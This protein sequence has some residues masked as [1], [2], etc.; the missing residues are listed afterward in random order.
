MAE[1]P[2]ER[3]K[4]ARHWLHSLTRVHD[5]LAIAELDVPWWTY[6]A[7]D[8]VDVWLAARP[9]PARVFEYGSG[10]S[11][12]WLARRAAE[13][14]SVEHHPGFGAM[15]SERLSGEGN[16]HLEV[17]EATL[18]TQP[19][20][21][22]GKEDYAGLDFAAYVDAMDAVEGTFDLVVV[23]GR[24]RE[25]CLAKA[26]PRLSRGGIVVYDNSARRRYRRAIEGCGLHEHAF[27]GL[28]PTLPYPDQTSVLVAPR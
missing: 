25:A 13:V 3:G 10:A 20:V 12:I 16:V 2:P 5:S 27:R 24:A 15:M 4:R 28:T 22:S 6:R 8:V 21:A 17:V 11:T 26:V 14:H 1:K 23:D 9:E 18:S 7:V 19:S